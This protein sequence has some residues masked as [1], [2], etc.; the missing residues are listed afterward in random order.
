MKGEIF[1]VGI[2]MSENLMRF[3]RLFVHCVLGISIGRAL[4]LLKA[5]K[6]LSAVVFF[7][8][9]ISVYIAFFAFE[10]LSIN[11]FNDY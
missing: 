4:A 2:Y 10:T 11:Q 6:K 5:D 7:L 9:G 1:V 3:F 8:T